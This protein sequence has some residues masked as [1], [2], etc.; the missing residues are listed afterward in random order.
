MPVIIQ[1]YL[2]IIILIIYFI[3]YHKLALQL[4]KKVFLAYEFKVMGI[5]NK[6]PL[7][8]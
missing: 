1:E 3:I 2:L 7:S 4:K 8:F 6:N 5:K